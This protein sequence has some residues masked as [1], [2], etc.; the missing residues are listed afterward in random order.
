MTQVL[1]LLHFISK[2]LLVVNIISQELAGFIDSFHMKRISKITESFIVIFALS[3]APKADPSAETT[4]QKTE[5]QITLLSKKMTEAELRSQLP[6]VM[7][8]YDHRA[9]SM[10]EYQLTLTGRNQIQEYYA[11]MFK[12][13]Q[14]KTFQ[15]HPIEFIHLKTTIV[16]IGLFE[17]EY[18]CSDV[19]SL[20]TTRG[21]Y[22]NVWSSRPDGTYRITGN[23]FNYFHPVSNPETLVIETSQK[24]PDESELKTI[25]PFE[26]KAY[27]ALMEK[28]V[29]QRNASLRYSFFTD[30]AILYPFADTVYNGID[31][32]KSHL[33]EYSSRGSVTIDT[34]NCYTYAFED[35]GSYILEYAMFKVKWSQKDISGRTEGKGIRIWKRQP[36]KSLRLF[37]E[38]GTHNFL[39]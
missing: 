4:T 8:Y 17:K 30:D 10:P 3:C 15:R 39:L 26:L 22:W 32:I 27:N 23:I 29:R 33:I 24:Q 5:Q 12:R 35:H 36:D 20:I 37:R 13:Q 31:Q 28:G 7:D 6:K 9:L 21:K 1:C 18:T 38:I 19:D 34:V 14:I 11:E 16:E 2:F 25:Q